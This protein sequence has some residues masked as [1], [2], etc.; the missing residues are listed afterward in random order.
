[1]VAWKKE[2]EISY[3]GVMKKYFILFLLLPILV[4]AEDKKE[5]VIHDQFFDPENQVL[6]NFL[7]SKSGDTLIRAANDKGHVFLFGRLKNGRTW[8]LSVDKRGFREGITAEGE[9]FSYNPNTNCLTVVGKQG[10][11]ATKIQTGEL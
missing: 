5:P 1:M 8:V 4:F 10:C 7:E 2:I 11:Q 3:W 6:Y 9:E